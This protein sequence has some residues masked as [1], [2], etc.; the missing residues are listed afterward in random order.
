MQQPPTDAPARPLRVA[1]A[2]LAAAALVALQFVG[3]ALVAWTGWPVPGSL[4]GMLLLLA[5]LFAHGRV[6]AGLDAVTAPLL[7]HMMLFLIPSVAAV[8]L[9]AALLREH[10][11]VFVLVSTVVTA[12]TLAATAWTLQR[13]LRKASA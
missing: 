11:L 2:L 4:V 7:R 13:L 9:S 8:G 10:A 12:L 3:D 1:R 6:P 5:A